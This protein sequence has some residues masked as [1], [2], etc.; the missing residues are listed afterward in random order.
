MHSAA[1]TVLSQEEEEVSYSPQTQ[2]ANTI[3][4]FDYQLPDL[5]P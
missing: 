4:P 1:G 2:V 3:D 5:L